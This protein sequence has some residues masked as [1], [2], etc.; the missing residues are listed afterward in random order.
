MCRRVAGKDLKE[1]VVLYHPDQHNRGGE[2]EL[3]FQTVSLKLPVL[4]RKAFVLVQTK[5]IA[6]LIFWL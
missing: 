4:I 3:C 5:D 1:N 2:K 6:S